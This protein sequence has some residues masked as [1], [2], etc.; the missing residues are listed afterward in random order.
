MQLQASRSEF[1]EDT[2]AKDKSESVPHLCNLNEDPMLSG[3]VK[4]FLEKGMSWGL[5][6]IR[7][8]GNLEKYPTELADLENQRKWEH[9][10]FWSFFLFMIFDVN[11]RR[12]ILWCFRKNCC[13]RDFILN[14]IDWS[15]VWANTC[16]GQNFSF[17]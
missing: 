3:V 14:I 2:S 16:L 13:S 6:L 9:G 5:P 10:S 1:K 7:I 17:T 4:H 8:V 12:L 11:N 15:T